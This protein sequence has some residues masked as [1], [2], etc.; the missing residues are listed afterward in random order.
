MLRTV[1][2]LITFLLPTQLGF[3]LW[4]SWSF[5]HGLSIDY[6]SITVYLTDLLLL[7][8][9]FIHPPRFL[10]YKPIKI[11]IT[12]IILSSFLGL[13][14]LN[15]LI[16]LFR[17]LLLLNYSHAISN[18][19]KTT[20]SLLL[21][22]I[23]IS[24]IVISL[25]AILQ[26]IAQSSL[27]GIFYW[28]GE[29]HFSLT[30]PGIAKTTLPFTYQQVIRSYATFSHP[31]SL[32]G[33]L[34]VISLLVII[35]KRKLKLNNL[36]TKTTLFISLI[37]LIT[38]FSRSAIFALLVSLISLTL[39]PSHSLFLTITI[40]LLLTL[41]LT[42]PILV[43]NQTSI[44]T[45]QLLNHY[46]LKAFRSNSLFGVGLNNFTIYLSQITPPLNHYLFQPAHNIYLLLL[47]QLG[48]VP[49]IT[50]IFIKPRLKIN[51]IFLPAILAISITGALDHY[52]LTLPQNRLLISFLGGLIFNSHLLNQPADKIPSCQL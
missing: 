20:L 23:S 37:A 2:T 43:G 51:K 35:L 38:T 18:Q 6:L 24:T 50:F 49:I 13:Q 3:H 48:A 14:P 28:L 7:T 1:L 12:T 17:I 29:R 25:L 10:F 41:I 32:A 44:T 52:W 27:D 30:T 47:S 11:L 22:S 40:P 21:T 39:S 4:P 33:H 5:I 19:N 31:N 16:F 26:F 46:A 15:S 9:L 45:R 8:L 36:L 34:I 42:L